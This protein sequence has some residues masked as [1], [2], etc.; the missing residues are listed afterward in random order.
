MHHPFA[1]VVERQGMGCDSFGTLLIHRKALYLVD[2][3]A[4][5]DAALKAEAIFKK[6]VPEHPVNDQSFAKSPFAEQQ[7]LRLEHLHRG[8][9]D[10]GTR[11]DDLRPAF[12]Q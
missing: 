7:F 8:L 10:Q 1:L 5:A 4:L 12:I 9:K 6:T 3:G 11:D 2:H